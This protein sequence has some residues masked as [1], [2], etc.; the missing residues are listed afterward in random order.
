M[1]IL[2]IC[3]TI[4]ATLWKHHHES[5]SLE[6]D[7]IIFLRSLLSLIVH[8]SLQKNIAMTLATYSRDAGIF[9]VVLPIPSMYGGIS[10][11]TCT[12]KNHPNDKCIRIVLGKYTIYMNPMGY[13]FFLVAGFLSVQRSGWSIDS[14]D[15]ASIGYSLWSLHGARGVL[16]YLDVAAWCFY[17]TY[18]LL[19]LTM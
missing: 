6:F 19:G 3:F 11:P 8:V 7:T 9:L 14:W 17:K 13:S 16:A 12:I 5:I 18:W 1:F 15:A 4:R 2:K 10:I